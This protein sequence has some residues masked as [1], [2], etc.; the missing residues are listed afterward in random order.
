ML[1]P[2]L[3][4][5]LTNLLQ[6]TTK[7]QCLLTKHSHCID[8]ARLPAAEREPQ[9]YK[10]PKHQRAVDPMLP[11]S[12]L[13]WVYSVVSAIHASN[14]ACFATQRAAVHGPSQHAMPVMLR[15]TKAQTNKSDFIIRL[16]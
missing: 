8:F 5:F 16:R 1:V 9:S 4:A 3:C 11:S 15:I 12:S 2:F 13:C 14:R 10:T 7:V 6:Y